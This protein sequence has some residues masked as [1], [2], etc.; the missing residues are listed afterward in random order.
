MSEPLR[1]CVWCACHLPR[2]TTL[3]FCSEQCA[4]AFSEDYWQQFK[5]RRASAVYRA[6]EGRSATTGDSSHN[7][8]EGQ[9]SGFL[10][11]KRR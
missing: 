5:L 7:L 4:D 11:S 1:R 6:A 3:Q 8:S 2:T 9:P 10:G